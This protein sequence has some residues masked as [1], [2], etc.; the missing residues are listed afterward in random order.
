MKFYE[1]APDPKRTST[2]LSM[3]EP[4]IPAS[5]FLGFLTFSPGVF[6]ATYLLAMTQVDVWDANHGD[7]PRQ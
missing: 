5:I 7:S 1:S 4:K 2:H 6:S 3:R